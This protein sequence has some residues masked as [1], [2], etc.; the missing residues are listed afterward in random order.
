MSDSDVDMDK[1][2]GPLLSDTDV[3]ALIAGQT[4]AGVPPELSDMLSMMRDQAVT[5]PAVPLT[6][7]ASEFVE[8]SVASVTPL[9]KRATTAA[10]PRARSIAKKAV[11]GFAIVPAKILIGATM[12]AAAVGGA[13]ALGVVH[14][15]ILP[16]S[17]SQVV[18][19]V[20]AQTLP[21]R[22]SDVVTVPTPTVPGSSEAAGTAPAAPPSTEGSGSATVVRS[23]PPR[24]T[25]S[26]VVDESS[27][28]SRSA[29]TRG[30]GDG[31]PG[32][33]AGKVTS[34]QRRGESNDGAP[35][36]RPDEGPNT[37]APTIAPCDEGAPGHTATSA[38]L[39]S[40]SSVPVD[41]SRDTGAP[42]SVPGDDTDR[43]GRPPAPTRGSG[44]DDSVADDGPGASDLSPATDQRTD[45]GPAHSGRD[46]A[47]TTEPSKNPGR[48]R[49]PSEG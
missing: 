39:D 2:M 11:A 20:P 21:P 47:S 6:G 13:Q 36:Q 34:E 49:T 38:P 45:S 24:E 29:P 16:G 18:S 25:V 22:S 32:C 7:A 43:S 31:E 15:P 8:E 44:T 48:G 30:A 5:G 14:V 33:E 12:A 23:V 37:T 26:P 28:S 10:S 46:S 40:T 27:N 3:E 4:V 1:T 41:R 17:G 42:P 35:V 9:R 19:S